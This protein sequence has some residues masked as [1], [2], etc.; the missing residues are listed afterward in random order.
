MHGRYESE[1]VRK[2]AELG[3]RDMLQ[4]PLSPY[5]PTGCERCGGMYE[6]AAFDIG[7]W[8]VCDC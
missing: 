5:A 6:H 2:L 3:Q 4:R 1:E 7:P 8:D